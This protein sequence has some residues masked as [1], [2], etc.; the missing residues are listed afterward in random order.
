MFFSDFCS[1]VKMSRISWTSAAWSAWTSW[2]SIIAVRVCVCC[3]FSTCSPSPFSDAITG[4]VPTRTPPHVDALV[5]GEALVDLFGPRAGVAIE[6]A[7]HLVPHP[8]GAPSNVAFQLAKHGVSVALVT[9]IGD[10]PLGARVARALADQGV[11][12][13]RIARRPGLRTGLTLV[14]VDAT[15]ERRFTP[16]RTGSADLT[17]RVDEVGSLDGVRL[18]HHGTV[19]L[20][21]A[22]ARDATFDAV[23]RAKAAGALVSA[24]INLRPGM[25]PDPDELRAAAEAARQTADVLKATVEEAEVIGAVGG[26]LSAARDLVARGAQ[27]AMITDGPRPAALATAAHAVEVTPPAV[28]VVDATGAGDAF[29]AA[30]LAALLAGPAPEALDADALRA[31]GE[32][33]ARAGAEACTHLG[34][35]APGP[36]SRSGS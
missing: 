26:A 32:R 22:P 4:A 14:E 29:V 31:L 2:P 27:L 15:G 21:E 8:G 9:A 19:S 1:F 30:A 23:R 20:R 24:D 16:W 12:T 28:A 13:S 10:D 17:L 7:S 3:V 6:D 33:A 34:A 35:I 25:Y 18:F 11:D 36:T 5:L